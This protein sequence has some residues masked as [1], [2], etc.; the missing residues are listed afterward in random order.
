MPRA[1]FQ[2]LVLPFVIED[3]VIKYGVFHRSD[4]DIWQFI[5]GGGEDDETHL[6]AA[7]RESF[8]EA[9]IENTN[10]F[11]KLDTLCSIP[12]WIFGEHAK[13][14]GNNCFV[15]NEYSFAVNLT[16]TN[17]KIANEHTNYK[18]LDYENAMKILKYDSNRTA[19]YELNKRI[20][21]NKMGKIL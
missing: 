12:V 5:A 3:N 7:K 16:D 13:A 17:L 4:M 10:S 19:L 18:W 8:E 14:W 6:Q 9:G 11:Y 20:M 21:D 2:V 1:N 15:V